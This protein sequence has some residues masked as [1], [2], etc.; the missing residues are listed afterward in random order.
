MTKTSTNRITYLRWHYASKLVVEF[1]DGTAVG[2][3]KVIGVNADSATI[4]ISPAYSKPKVT[5]DIPYK[6]KIISYLYDNIRDV[7][8]V[9][10]EAQ[11]R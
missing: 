3:Y 7:R 6:K 4:V 11:G 5:T 10:Y 2:Y 9:D 8:K 1:L